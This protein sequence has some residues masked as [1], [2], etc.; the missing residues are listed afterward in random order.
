MDSGFCDTAH[1]QYYVGPRCGEKKKEKKDKVMGA[2]PTK[3]KMKLLRR[4][5]NNLSALSE[6]GFGLDIQE[7][8]V[9]ELGN[10]L[11]PV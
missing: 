2:L 4:F 3:K 11:T 8:F 9:A 10:K 5:S 6:I 7:G 1:V